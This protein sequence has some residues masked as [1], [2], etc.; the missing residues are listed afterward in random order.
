MGQDGVTLKALGTYQ[1]T[2]VSLSAGIPLGEASSTLISSLPKGV[3]LVSVDDSGQADA[4]N[5]VALVP[6]KDSS[7]IADWVSA[8]NA[9]TSTESIQ[10]V[11]VSYHVEDTGLRVT[12]KVVPV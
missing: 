10:L 8:F 11:P 4:L 9:A 3:S 7:L 12:L 2:I 1:Q 6:S 5:V